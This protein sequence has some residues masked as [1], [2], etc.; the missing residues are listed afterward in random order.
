MTVTVTV[1]ATVTVPPQGPE[2]L[3]RAL[4]HWDAGRT[5]RIDL[6]GFL[7]V[8]NNDL[9]LSEVVDKHALYK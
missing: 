2:V 8:W 3:T 6:M 9:K 7:H 5:D 4:R 1:T